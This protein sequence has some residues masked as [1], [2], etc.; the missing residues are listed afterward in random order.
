MQTP[1]QLGIFSVIFVVS[2]T[3]IISYN[4]NYEI[5]EPEQPIPQTLFWHTPTKCFT[6]TDGS[7]GCGRAYG[8]TQ[9]IDG[10]VRINDVLIPLEEFVN[11]EDE[12]A[13]WHVE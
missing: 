7:N 5:L 2:L 4:L 3:L 9:I 10:M 6:Y 1:E 12:V 13:W 11:D 8:S